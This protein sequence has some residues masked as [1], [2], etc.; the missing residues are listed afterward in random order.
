MVDS[1]PPKIQ[2]L[3]HAFW[4]NHESITRSCA[5]KNFISHSIERASNL[6]E[7]N[8]LPPGVSLK[9][10]LAEEGE[11]IIYEENIDK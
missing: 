10:S 3:T 11:A 2:L 7:M 1:C 6:L 9:E 4:Y 8:V 5:F